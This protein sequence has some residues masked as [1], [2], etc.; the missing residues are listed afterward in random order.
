MTTGAVALWPLGI[1]SKSL[2][3]VPPLVNPAPALFT[4]SLSG[5]LARVGLAEELP[6]IL[7]ARIQVV[8][9]DIV[10]ADVDQGGIVQAEVIDPLVD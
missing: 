10:S 2:P 4:V 6:D 1:N 7:D 3:L 5:D 8:C 9:A